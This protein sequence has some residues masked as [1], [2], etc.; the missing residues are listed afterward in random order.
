MKTIEGYDIKIFTDNIEQD[1][2]EQLR[3]LLTRTDVFEGCQVRVMSDCLT[4]DTEIL[5]TD[6]FKLIVDLKPGELVANYNLFTRKISFLPVKNIII[7]EK[8]DSEKIYRYSCSR[9]SY[10]FCVSENHRMAYLRNLGTKSKNLERFNTKENIWAGEGIDSI[11]EI[12]KY[13]D[14]DIRLLTW[15]IGD[16]SIKKNKGLHTNFRVRWS[17]KKER[18]IDRVLELLN[19]NKYEFNTYVDSRDNTNIYMNTK[20]SKKFIE[21]LGGAKE[22]PKDFMY[23]PKNQVKILLDELIQVDGDYEA[24]LRN[25]TYRI[26]TNSVNTANILQSIFSINGYFTKT[27]ARISI[28]YRKTISFY[29]SIIPGNKIIYSKSGFHNSEYTREEIDYNYRLVCVETNTG[30][31]VARQNLL[32]FVTG[33]CHSGAGCVI[34]FTSE[35]KDKVISNIVGV[36]LGCAVLVHKLSAQPDSRRLQDTI[37]AYI[38]YGHEVRKDWIN[39]KPSYQ[40]YRRKASELIE[41]LKCKKELRNIGRLADSVGSLGGGEVK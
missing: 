26:S 19:R 21:Y 15:I 41:D 33:N 14:D 2:L 11:S 16:G 37:E 27:Y 4:E 6:G 38:P 40:K 7:R 29:V 30:Y 5:T 35:M 22:F 17:F 9:G 32:T 13:S 25:G 3:T 12:T 10:S 39:I 23:L 1:A 8:R 20:S 28:G 31:F 34:G 24:F 36:D 18:K